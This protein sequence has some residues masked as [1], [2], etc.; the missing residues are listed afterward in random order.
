MTWRASN[1]GHQAP[2]AACSLPFH[3]LPTPA[4]TRW[5]GGALHTHTRPAS[6]CSFHAASPHL[7]Q[8]LLG[9]VLEVPLAHGHLAGH[10]DLGLVA[11]HLDVLAQHA[12]SW[13]QHGILVLLVRGSRPVPVV[14]IL[15][16]A[17]WRSETLP[18]SSATTGA[19]WHA[20]PRSTQSGACCSAN[21]PD[22]RCSAASSRPPH[23]A[24]AAG[25]RLPPPS[26]YIPC[27]KAPH[28]CLL[29]PA[30]V[31]LH[32]PRSRLQA[33]CCGCAIWSR[34]CRASTPLRCQ[35]PCRCLIRAATTQP[36]ASCYLQQQPG[37]QH[38]V[39]AQHPATLHFL[40]AKML[41]GLAADLDL[42]GQ[43]LLKGRN[44]HDLNR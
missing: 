44:L 21:P 16:R 12:C 1:R 6:P 33:A 36:T 42:V 43:E 24:S 9:E 27:P 40:P 7:L 30:V 18:A 8:E 5:A 13:H 19:C 25:A 3:T 34:S 15:T 38:M 28:S 14:T 20:M 29:L 39:N 17:L 35:A 10:R 22:C 37:Q 32:S 31:A 11:G 23:A 4:A 2:A 41:T 26:P